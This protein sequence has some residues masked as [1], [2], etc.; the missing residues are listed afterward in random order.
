MIR[1]PGHIPDKVGTNLDKDG[2]IPDKAG[3]SP[4][5]VGTTLEAQKRVKIRIGNLKK[6]AVFRIFSKI[7]PY[8]VL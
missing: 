6:I 4:D 2:T 3:T 7:S 8:L 1:N 5:K